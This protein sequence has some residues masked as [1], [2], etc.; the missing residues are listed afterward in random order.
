MSR[1]IQKHF[2]VVLCTVPSEEVGRR[3]ALDLVEKKLA[4]CVN[5]VGPIESIYW[6]KGHVQVDAEYQLIIKTEASHLDE[7][8]VEIR[9]IHPYEVPEFVVI[10]AQIPF[11]AYA[12][13]LKKALSKEG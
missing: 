11:S 10:P 5:R 2:V 4:A 12:D 7:L 13:W 8:L 1:Q 3:I 6:W 9:A